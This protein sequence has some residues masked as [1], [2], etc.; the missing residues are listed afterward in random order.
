MYPFGG[1]AWELPVKKTACSLIRDLKESHKG[2]VDNFFYV[3]VYDSPFKLFG[4]R[5]EIWV[6]AEDDKQPSEGRSMMPE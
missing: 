4:R 2:V 5:N 6:L 1:Y 3:A